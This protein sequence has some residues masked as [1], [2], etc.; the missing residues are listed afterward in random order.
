LTGAEFAWRIARLAQR[1]RERQAASPEERAGLEERYRREDAELARTHPHFRPADP[2]PGRPYM[3]DERK[4]AGDALR[5]FVGRRAEREVVPD[6][7]DVSPEDRAAVLEA[8]R[9]LDAELN[10]PPLPRGPIAYTDDE[11]CPFLAPDVYQRMVAAQA[12][13]RARERQPH[14]SDD[15]PCT[16][17]SG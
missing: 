1:V 17:A 12:K 14:V 10:L 7:L 13:P 6:R 3:A 4:E 2:D 9:Q 11:L 15:T 5:R 16:A 8:V